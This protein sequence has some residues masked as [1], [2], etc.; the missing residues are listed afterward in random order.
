MQGQVELRHPG[1][2]DVS[3]GGHYPVEI[4]SYPHNGGTGT[5]LPVSGKWEVER[6]REGKL[7]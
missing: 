6:M 2:P 4:P 3:Q 5:S 7:D 1:R